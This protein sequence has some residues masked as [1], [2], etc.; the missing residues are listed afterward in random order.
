MDK[1]E[2]HE[3]TAGLRV[4]SERL[5]LAE[6]EARLGRA[7][8]GRDI[9]DPVSRRRADSPRRQHALWSIESSVERTRP[10]DE[11]IDEVLTFAE[12]HRDTL[13][14]LRPDCRIDIFCGVFSGVEAQGGFTFEPSLSRRLNDLQLPVVVDLY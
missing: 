10:L 3:Y 8:D 14:A 7:T 11:H 2:R 6:L 4:F 1:S 5:K 12:K 9:G 13:D